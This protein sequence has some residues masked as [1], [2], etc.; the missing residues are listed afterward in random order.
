MSPTKLQRVLL[1]IAGLSTVTGLALF[2]LNAAESERTAIDV[3]QLFAPI[4]GSAWGALAI[5]T[6]S[7]SL[8]AYLPVELSA[9][10]PCAPRRRSPCA[11]GSC[12]KLQG[13]HRSRCS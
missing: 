1:A 11:L 8:R 10:S 4:L 9:A 7:S 5:D 13:V 6:S 3:L 12:K 2:L